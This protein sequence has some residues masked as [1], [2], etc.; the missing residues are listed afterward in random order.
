[1]M[2]SSKQLNIGDSVILVGMFGIS[3]ITG[4]FLDKNHNIFY[5]VETERGPLQIPPD[6]ILNRINSYNIT[7]SKFNLED[8]VETPFVGTIVGIYYN[9]KAYKYT[10][11][12]LSKRKVRKGIKESSIN[13]SQQEIEEMENKRYYERFCNNYCRMNLSCDLCP[14]NEYRQ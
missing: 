7:P 12:V 1:M 2:N 10:Y 6:S 3:Y 14:L 5:I 13:R 8:T 9:W 11:D 4:K